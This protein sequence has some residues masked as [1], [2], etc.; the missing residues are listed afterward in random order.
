[1]I[2]VLKITNAITYLTYKFEMN[3]QTRTVITHKFIGDTKFNIYTY[4]HKITCNYL[5]SFYC[6]NTN[7]SIK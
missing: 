4:K 7:K 6:T 3:N 5:P 2:I 1:M